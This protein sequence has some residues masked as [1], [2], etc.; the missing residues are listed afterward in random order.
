[1]LELLK[2]DDKTQKTNKYAII[3]I[4]TCFK[5][6]LLKIVQIIIIKFLAEKS[7]L[8]NSSAIFEYTV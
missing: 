1:M 6:I 5:E 3:L 7:W 4:I 8:L 2:L